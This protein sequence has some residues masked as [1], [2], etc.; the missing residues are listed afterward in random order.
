MAGQGRWTTWTPTITQSGSVT[1]TL[2]FARYT[3]VGSFVSLEAIMNITGTGTTSNP[4]SIGG[5]PA[6]LRPINTAGT[7]HVVG[8]MNV[9][10]TS[11]GL[12]FI[13]ALMYAGSNSFQAI[14]D[15]T[16]VFVGST[17]GLASGDS[18]GISAHYEI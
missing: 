3:I 7:L 12:H 16:G 10:D 17:F 14:R 8:V 15:N 13:G 4:I 18:I 2:G 5:M 9:V 11:A 6:S 1:F